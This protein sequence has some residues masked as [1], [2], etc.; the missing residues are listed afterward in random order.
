MEPSEYRW[1]VPDAADGQRDDKAY[2]EAEHRDREYETTFSVGEDAGLIDTIIDEALLASPCREILIVGCGSRIDLQSKLLERAPADTNI[3]ATDFAAV[4]EL[5][6][7][8][9]SHPRLTYVALEHAEPFIDAFDV[10]IAVNVLVMDSDA[11]N[12]ALVDAWARALNEHGR[13]VMLAPLL[14]CGQ[15]LALLSGR[16]DIAECLDLDRSSW[17]EKRQG[18]REI[19]YSPLR[20]RRILKEAGLRLT[21]LRVVF[22]DGPSSREEARRSY[23]L[24]DDDLLVYEQLVVARRDRI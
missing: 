22:L 17:T 24:D 16:S 4:V 7:E 20:M 5:A 21:N 23:D 8:R 9:F 18:T 13:L 12:R 15:D 11:A 3:T 14:F 2:W 19:E 10:V 1:L 6:R